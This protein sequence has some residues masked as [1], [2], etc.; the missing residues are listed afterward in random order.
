M[1]IAKVTVRVTPRHPQQYFMSTMINPYRSIV[2]CKLDK[3]EWNAETK[4]WVYPSKYTPEGRWISPESLMNVITPGTASIL[5]FSNVPEEPVVMVDYG[6]GG[7]YITRNSVVTYRMTEALDWTGDTSKTLRGGLNVS[8]V[9]YTS[10]A[11]IDGTGTAT[12]GPWWDDESRVFRSRVGVFGRMVVKYE[13]TAVEYILRFD[14][15]EDVFGVNFPALQDEWGHSQT[16]VM[17]TPVNVVF[18]GNGVASVID[19]PRKFNPP[20]FGDRPFTGTQEQVTRIKYLT[21]KVWTGATEEEIAAKTTYEIHRRIVQYTTVNS[22]TGKTNVHNNYYGDIPETDWIGE[23]TT[24][25]V[26]GGDPDI[27]GGID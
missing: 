8:G 17:G 2:P 3:G 15:G 12:D 11:F 21:Y 1:A 4:S 7:S 24:E 18:T 25:E 23:I 5:M 19:V 27:L 22:I 14:A 20:Y 9:E 16:E 10:S 26:P 13:V 6:T